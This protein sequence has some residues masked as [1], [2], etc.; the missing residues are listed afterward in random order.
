MVDF[1]KKS[2]Q[3]D[4]SNMR[5][6]RAEIIADEV[7]RIA[8]EPEGKKILDFGAGTGLI[9]F[10]FAG[11]NN[12]LIG[13]DSSAGM[14]NVLNEKAKITGIDV[15]AVQTDSI[16]DVADFGPFDIIV[17]GML[18][19]HMD[20]PAGFIADSYQAAADGAC[21]FAADLCKED[22]SFHQDGNEGVKHFGFSEPEIFKM[23]EDAGYEDTFYKEIFEIDKEQGAY[24]V[25]LAGG[26]K[27]ENTG[28]KWKN[29]KTA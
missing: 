17:S 4:K 25:F 11:K 27:F 26:R 24:P 16:N 10:H 2:K 8:G 15:Q 5:R 21:F 20:D 3:W 7:C 12:T 14:I 1:D 19:H 6:I 22:G 23:L 29:R 13:A 9:L 18:L 28:I